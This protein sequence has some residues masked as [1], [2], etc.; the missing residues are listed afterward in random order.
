[1]RLIVIDSSVMIDTVTFVLL[2]L[3]KPSSVLRRAT[4]MNVICSLNK[5][6]V[7]HRLIVFQQLAAAAEIDEE[8]V[9]KAKQ[10]RSEK[11][12]RKVG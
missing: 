11:K 9:S 10:S 5:K 8:P 7:L 2:S 6:K 4:Y 12:A 3:L 1:M